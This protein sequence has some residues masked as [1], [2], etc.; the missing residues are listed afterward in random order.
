[1]N[2]GKGAQA[3]RRERRAAERRDARTSTAEL[4]RPGASRK[5]DHKR[6]KVMSSLAKRPDGQRSDWTRSANAFDP[7]QVDQRWGR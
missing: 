1:M 5:T 2:G 4:M 3:R 7:V 6:S